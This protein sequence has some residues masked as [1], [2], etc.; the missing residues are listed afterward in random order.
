MRELT[1]ALML[2]GA[3][4]GLIISL[5][6]D[7]IFPSINKNVHGKSRLNLWLRMSTISGIAIV[8]TIF[9]LG[10]YLCLKL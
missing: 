1:L 5:I 9:M 6:L 2:I 10:L 8:L 4:P 3:L 7:K